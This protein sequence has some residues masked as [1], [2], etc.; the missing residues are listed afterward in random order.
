MSNLPIQWPNGNGPAIQVG[1]IL[2]GKDK[3]EREFTVTL[4]AGYPVNRL[5]KMLF[6]TGHYSKIELYSKE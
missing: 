3:T 4:P 5:W 1:V 6:V 2:T